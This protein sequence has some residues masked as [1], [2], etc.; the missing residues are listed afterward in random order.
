VA[1]GNAEQLELQL[2]QYQGKSDVTSHLNKV[3]AEPQMHRHFH[4]RMAK[5][6]VAK[7]SRAASVRLP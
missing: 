5:C 2:Q 1:D 3:R 4:E 6:C 7:L